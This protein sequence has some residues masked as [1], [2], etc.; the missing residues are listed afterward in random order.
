MKKYINNV[1][2]IYAFAVIAGMVG[3]CLTFSG[4]SSINDIGEIDKQSN[5]LK[6]S[7]TN[8]FVITLVYVVSAFLPLIGKI[9][10]F[11]NGCILGA[12]IGWVLK[13]NAILMLLILPHGIFEIPCLLFTGV[14]IANGKEWF[15]KEPAR[16]LK[17]WFFH[18]LSVFLIAIIEVYVTPFIY[19]IFTR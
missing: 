13:T 11:R 6:I 1:A 14:I 17:Y 18:I 7:L 5:F 10:I 2:W 16:F 3:G 8:A 12:T 4:E 19:E 9:I 15:R